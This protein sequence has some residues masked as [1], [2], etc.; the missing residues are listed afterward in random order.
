MESGLVS[1]IIPTRNRAHFLP[2]AL[3]SI[4]AQTYPNF[5]IL[6]VDDGSTD[7]TGRVVEAYDARLRYFLQRH[8]GVSAARNRALAEARGEYVAFL[9]DDDMFMPQ[10]LEK[11]V[12]YLDEHPDTHWVY[13]GFQLVD[14]YN[15]PLPDG[16]IIPQVERVGLHE[17][18]C[19]I[20]MIPSSLMARAEV[21]RQVGGFP[22]G[23]RISEDY[24][25]WAKLAAIGGGGVVPD[26]LTM[27]RIHKGNTRL[28]YREHLK[29]NTRILDGLLSQHAARLRPREYYME[30]LYRI[31]SDNLTRDGKPIQLLLFRLEYGVR[32][33]WR[34]LRQP[35]A[36]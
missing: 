8:Q 17:I 35:A 6:V 4:Y 30:N 22:E 3:D 13:S 23:V 21:L 36:G 29:Q 7:Q 28:P 12:A 34:R 25:V 11:Q 33:W 19:F 24:H 14:Q 10:K 2:R 5:E 32:E 27:F 15:A 9:D 31:I 26:I 1:I 16:A 18:A 20:F